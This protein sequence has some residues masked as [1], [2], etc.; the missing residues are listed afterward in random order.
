MLE[1][2]KFFP[3]VKELN[4]GLLDLK[5]VAFALVFQ[6]MLFFWRTIASEFK[7]A[8]IAKIIVQLCEDSKEKFLD[9]V[10]DIKKNQDV[11]V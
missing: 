10:I 5:L 11:H 9:S 7:S 4:P 6:L 8:A 3:M 2:L 1:M